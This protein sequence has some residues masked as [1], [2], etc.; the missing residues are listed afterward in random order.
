[1]TPVIPRAL[2]GADP[3]RLPADATDVLVVGS[4]VAGLSLALELAGRCRVLLVTKGTLA[5]AAT[6]YAQGGIAAVLGPPDSPAGHLA[7]TLAAGAGLCDPAAVRVLVDEAADAVERLVKAGVRLDVRVPSGEADVTVGRLVKAGTRLDLDA[8]GY[9]RTREGGHGRARVLHAGGDATG[10]EIEEALAIAVRRAPGVDLAERTLLLDLL[11]DAEGA[12][13]G[14]VLETGGSRRT[15]R[16]RAVVLATGGA[17]QLFAA[18]TNPPASTG[19]G[20]AAALRAG[21]PLADLELVQFHPTALHTPRDPRPLVTEALRGEGAVLRDANGDP[22]MAGAHPL[23]DLAPRDVVTRTM[24]A[25]MTALGTDHL[26]LDATGLGAGLLERRFP[27][28]LGLC[29]AAGVDP[30]T[31]PIPVSPAAHYLMGGI[32]TDLD[33]RAGLPGLWAIGEAASTGVHGA[34]RLA[35]NS[36]LE[37]AVFGAR[38]AVAL[39]AGLPA[40]GR[41]VALPAPPGASGVPAG[42]RRALRALMTAQTGVLRDGPGL[43]DTAAVLAPLAAG[44]GRE[45][46][47]LAQLGVVMATLAGRREESR[48]A[49]WRRDFPGPRP[50]WR[51]R[52][53]ATR[54]PDGTL[55]VD[56]LPVADLAVAR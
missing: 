14:A 54:A 49:H 56:T 5:D 7:D 21:A 22:V 51:V 20:I 15:L 26:L 11:T 17:G 1:V 55:V 2:T 37:G 34:N 36:L 6:R 27:T 10:R 25:R 40:P 9:A 30:V 33:G 29:R 19:D 47:G 31:T 35:S 32:R 42:A 53:T 12:V 50:E 8:V 44:A 13:A 24:A 23:G 4:G 45:L 52:Q 43:A 28:V 16:A 46:A 38:A 41:P 48:G 39:A 3:A 18:T